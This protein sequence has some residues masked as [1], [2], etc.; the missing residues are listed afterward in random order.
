[1]EFSAELLVQG[2]SQ[3]F[4]PL[5]RLSAFMLA[6]PIF[7]SRLIA[8][9]VRLLLALLV[10]LLLVPSLPELPKV[11]GFGLS[12]LLLVVQQT[13]IGF[14]AGFSMQVAF[15]VVVLGGQFIAMK[16]GLGFASMNDPSN[17]VTVTIVSQ[18]YLMLVTLLFVVGD[19]HLLLL[20]ILAESFYSLP[21]GSGWV[22][23]ALLWDLVATGS[24]MFG[25]ALLLALPVLTSLMIVNIS[26]G[27]MGRSAPQMNIF[28]VGFPITLILGMFL[29]WFGF[30]TFLGNYNQFMQEGFGLLRH[31]LNV[32]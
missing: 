13:L 26:F 10:T 31:L 1:M 29:I 20:R 11:E 14:V 3:Y 28:T 16:M 19:G 2:A 5:A 25:A 22:P 12:T 18:Y 4:L 24:W 30:T 15:Q 21:I 23:A 27:V 9:R 17:G 7:G 6:A 32:S 8:T